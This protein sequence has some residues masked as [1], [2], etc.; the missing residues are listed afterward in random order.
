[1]Q[2]IQRDVLR[3]LGISEEE[4]FRLIDMHACVNYL[5]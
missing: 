5:L 1:M 2:G 4:I 3:N